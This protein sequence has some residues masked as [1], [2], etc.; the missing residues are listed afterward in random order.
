[1]S[2]F[3]TQNTAEED[4]E[5]LILIPPRVHSFQ[6]QAVVIVEV[7]PFKIHGNGTGTAFISQ[8]G[9]V[10]WP[11]GLQIHLPGQSTLWSRGSSALGYPDAA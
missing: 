7:T 6:S 11:K 2:A 9:H 8:L 1:M 4:S 10:K 5:S 3:F